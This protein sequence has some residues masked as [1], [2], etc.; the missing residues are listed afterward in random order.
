MISLCSDK[1]MLA[2]NAFLES[3]LWLAG[4]HRPC[5]LE[6]AGGLNSTHPEARLYPLMSIV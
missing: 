2:A 5:S 6:T 3:L 1:V 4:D